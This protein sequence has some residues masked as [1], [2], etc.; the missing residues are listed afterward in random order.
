MGSPYVVAIANIDDCD[1]AG[2][3]ANEV[4]KALAGDAR[5]NVE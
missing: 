3:L 1:G 2:L 5:D 4:R